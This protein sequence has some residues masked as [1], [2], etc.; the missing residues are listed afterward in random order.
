MYHNMLCTIS[1]LALG[2]KKAKEILD[3]DTVK[4]SII[5]TK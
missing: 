2:N 3:T 5:S 1:R 4:E